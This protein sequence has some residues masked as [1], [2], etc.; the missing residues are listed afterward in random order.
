MTAL[1]T[2][3][4]QGMA[5]ALA[6]TIVLRPCRRLNAATRHV[7]WWAVLVAILALPWIPRFGTASAPAA[8]PV[9]GPSSSVLTPIVLPS[10]PDWVLAIGIGTWLGLVVLGLLRLS[11]GLTLVARLKRESEDL[12]EGRQ[13]ALRL[14]S[15]ARR[16]GRPVAL[17]VSGRVRTACAVGLGRGTIVLPRTLA[18]ALGDEALDQIVMHEHAHLERRDDLS[19]MVQALI[20]CVAGLHPAVRFAAWHIDLEREAACDDRVVERTGAASRYA[21]CLAEAAAL[22][23][24]ARMTYQPA[25]LPGAV[26]G[27]SA[28]RLRVRRL[29]E[30]GRGRTS[31]LARVATT[32]S[33]VALGMAVGV[34]SRMA[35]LVAF[36]EASA[37]TVMLDGVAT[38]APAARLLSR[39]EAAPAETAA[40]QTGAHPSPRRTDIRARALVAPSIRS[41][42]PEAG[43]EAIVATPEPEPAAALLPTRPLDVPYDAPSGVSGARPAAPERAETVAA[44][45]PWSAAAEAGVAVGAAAKRGGVAVGAGAKKAG[46]AIA[47]FFVR[48][49][50]AAGGGR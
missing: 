30:P 5:L 3:L 50:R 42:A 49:G 16:S 36:V 19:R 46:T 12:P 47:G 26:R 6:A 9:S 31:R 40:R 37:G 45:T 23:S 35:P 27:S 22:A 39:E 21:S 44:S 20:E 2:W 25:L 7:I 34:S 17:R 11:R 32:A 18:E 28:L 43:R 1:V 14:W 29:L 8:A 41:T 13:M 48:S 24:S 10:A 33:V 4:W 15:I 38:Q